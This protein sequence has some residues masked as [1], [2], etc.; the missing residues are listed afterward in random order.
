[1]E[2]TKDKIEDMFESV[3]DSLREGL[4]KTSQICAGSP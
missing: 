4:G 1:M 3:A 2:V